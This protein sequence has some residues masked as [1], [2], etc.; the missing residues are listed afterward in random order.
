MPKTFLGTQNFENPEIKIIGI[1]LDIT[2]SFLNGTRFGPQNIRIASENLETYSVV[3]KK[4]LK[5]KKISDLGDIE[6]CSDIKKALKMIENKIDRE[7]KSDAK[8]ILIGGEHTLSLAS[9]KSFLK[10]FPKLSLIW[11]DA[12]LDLRDSYQNNKLSHATVLRRISEISDI[13]I[14]HIGFRSAIK[15]ELEFAKKRVTL[16]KAS[17]KEIVKIKRSLKYEPVYVSFD[18]DFI[19]PDSVRSVGCPEPGG[20][21]FNEAIEL[22]YSLKGLNIVGADFVEY[23]GLIDPYFTDGTKI[24]KLIREFLLFI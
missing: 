21:Y 10:K 1:P 13:K 3:L 12:H 9:I 15:E 5:D 11:F 4:D 16:L 6:I 2:S 17:K 24:A 23:N 18:V 14:F 8:L 19:N 7:L 22:M 20:V